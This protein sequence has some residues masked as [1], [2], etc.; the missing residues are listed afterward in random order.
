MSIWI[1]NQKKTNRT[2]KVY[3]INLPISKIS[4]WGTEHRQMANFS[5][6]IF[7]TDKISKNHDFGI[8]PKKM[9]IWIENQKNR[10]EH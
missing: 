10:T 4:L 6:T 1:D 5:K 2:L 9:S 7:W 8:T 3:P